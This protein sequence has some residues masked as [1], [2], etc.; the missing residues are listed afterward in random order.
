MVEFQIPLLDVVVTWKK[1]GSVEAKNR[2]GQEY[3]RR[4]PPSVPP[5][6]KSK[7]RGPFPST[8]HPPLLLFVES[9]NPPSSKPQTTKMFARVNSITLYHRLRATIAGYL[10]PVLVRGYRC[11][12]KK[13]IK[14]KLPKKDIRK[15]HHMGHSNKQDL[16]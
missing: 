15:P 12:D 10:L 3:I 11:F 9:T 13:S 2:A 14:S 4:I 16:C 8:V 1:T 6:S 7:V 5:C